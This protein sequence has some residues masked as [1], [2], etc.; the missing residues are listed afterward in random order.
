MTSHRTTL[1]CLAAATLAAACSEQPTTPVDV[2]AP[3]PHF[4]KGGVSSG[5]HFQSA[6]AFF[7]PSPTLQVDFSLAGVGAGTTVTVTATADASATESCVNG[8]DKVPSDKKKTTTVQQVETSGDFDATAGGNVQG[9]LFLTFP[10]SALTCPNGQ[11][12]TL[13]SGSWSNVQLS[14]PSPSGGPVLQI[15]VSGTFTL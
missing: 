13:F 11:I 9:T 1:L 6:T 5:T 4:G 14:T 7:N 15:S 8:G 3:P 2:N 10:P 12:A